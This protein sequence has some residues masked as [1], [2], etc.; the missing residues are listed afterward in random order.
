MTTRDGER[1]IP[2]YLRLQGRVLLAIMLRES[3]AR[4]GDR[5]AG[6]L[7]ALVEPVTHIFGLSLLFYLAG[8]T[9]PLEGGLLIFM[10]TGYVV[11]LPFRRL[12]KTMMGGYSSG[13][14]L[15]TFPVVKVF[16]VFLGRGILYLSTWF[17]TIFIVIGVLIGSGNAAMPDNVFPMI[18]AIFALWAIGFG[19]G[20]F[21]GLVTQF[22]PSV[23]SIL[24]L[25]RRML[26]FTS[27]VFF[28]PD[29]MPP[30]FRDIILWNPIT[31][32]II[33]FREGYYEMYKSQ[34]LDLQYLFG[35]SIFSV[36]IALVAER[37]MR[38][39]LRALP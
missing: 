30:V 34:F 2:E 9:A 17:V 15:L 25:P 28:L 27:G 38:K 21:L 19:A 36:F 11:F 7:W 20:A 33:L 39:A 31:H 18:V 29:T 32:A 35:W 4:Y 22:Y 13:E 8:R 5:Q 23:R 37:S 14:S 1:M 26:Y 24:R 6:Y 3:R 16:D 12:L 10:A